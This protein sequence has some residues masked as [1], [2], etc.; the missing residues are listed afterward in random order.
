[1]IMKKILVILILL[2]VSV[3]SFGKTNWNGE[4]GRLRVIYKLLD[5]LIVKVEDPA[6]IKANT[7]EKKFT[8][9]SKNKGKRIKV[10][11]SA[12]Y[13][14]NSIDNFLREIYKYVYFE[15]ENSGEFNLTSIDAGVKENQNSGVIKGKGYFV[16]ESN[17]IFGKDRTTYY[18]KEFSSRVSSSPFAATTEIDVDFTLPDQEIPM[19]V[20]KGSMILNVWFGGTI[21]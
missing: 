18:S 9:S 6:R 3:V 1:M 2:F 20:Y 10:D 13:N 16:D 7:L 12:P 4:D 15:L 11:V 17:N 8:Y 21:K 5:P 14:N 19:G